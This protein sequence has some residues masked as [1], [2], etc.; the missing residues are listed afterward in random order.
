MIYE[1][2]KYDII[3]RCFSTK[4]AFLLEEA[5]ARDVDAMYLL[6]ILYFESDEERKQD[7]YNWF[8]RA[9]EQ[10]Q[11][12]A[13]YY[14]GN[15]YAYPFG[16]GVVKAS[17]TKAIEY[18]SKAIELGSAKAMCELGWRYRQGWNS[19]EKNEEKAV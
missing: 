9:S 17:D 19:I 1:D 4:E 11:A 3:D 2:L 8:L 10:G 6:G 12:D 14:L 13:T 16:F 5:T 15:F 7:S 18:W